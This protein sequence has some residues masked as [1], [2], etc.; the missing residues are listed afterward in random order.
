MLQRFKNILAIPIVG[1]TLKLSSSNVI[2]YLLPIIVTP[3]LSRI[4]S[5]DL[6]GEWGIFAS[7]FS[8]ISVVMFLS[9]DYVVVRAD[10]NETPSVL[11]LC[12]TTGLVVSI[13]TS[14]VLYAGA[15][16]N[17]AFFVDFPSRG[18]FTIYLLL[19]TFQVIFQNLLNR[20]K[21]YGILSI[22]NIVTGG[23][24]AVL[25]LV[26]GFA[27]FFSNGLIAG[28]V[29]AHVLCIIYIAF[30]L[31]PIFKKSYYKNVSLR[32][33]RAAAV[34]YKKF[35]IYDAPASLLHFSAFNLPIIILSFFYPKSYIG[36]YSIVVQLLILPISF[37]GSAMGK[38][39]YQQISSEGTFDSLKKSTLYV[40]KIL[41]FLSFIPS[42]FIALGG[43][44]LIVWFLGSDWKMAG[45]IAL[46]LTSWSVPTILTEPLK[47][48]FRYLNRQNVLLKFEVLYF[49]CTLGGLT[50]GCV[51]GLQMPI[52]ILLYALTCAI[53]RFCLFAAILKQTDTKWSMIPKLGRILIIITFIIL[54]IR[55][56]LF[57]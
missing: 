5:P 8:I 40:L 31:H 52:V 36:G 25:R 34:K 1:N 20:E 57:F 51:Y 3:I 13:I 9:Y 56:L 50:L 28:T 15:A 44:K 42:L 2:L 26:F 37:I 39:Y 43:D 49:I 11:A 24:Q 33:I 30:F 18:F 4:Y 10:N 7:A 38:V 27:V 45:I 35:P 53:V 16:L 41:I 54:I 21:R 48:S 17:I 23:S 12:I 22:S 32:S 29:F 14:I 47:F 6:F 19:N 55:Y 46:C